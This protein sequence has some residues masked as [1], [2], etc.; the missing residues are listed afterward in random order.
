MLLSRHPFDGDPT[1][2]PFSTEA[3]FD[4]WADKGVLAARINVPGAAATVGVLLTHLQA[5]R[6]QAEV[7]RLQLAD[8]ANVADSLRLSRTHMALIAMG[9]FNVI[10]EDHN[11]LQTDE[12]KYMV[13]LLNLADTW[14][15]QHPNDPG[16]TSAGGVNDLIREFGEDKGERKRLDYILYAPRPSFY[17]HCEPTSCELLKYQSARGIGRDDVRDLSDHYGIVAEYRIDVRP[18]GAITYHID[19][20]PD[21]PDME[22]P[23][24][25]SL[26]AW[27]EDA[28]IGYARA[29]LTE[30]AP[31]IRVSYAD[32]PLGIGRPA[33]ERLGCVFLDPQPLFNCRGD[34][35]S[36]G[37]GYDAQ[38]RRLD[39]AY[40]LQHFTGR[41][42]H[43][44]SPRSDSV[45]QT[46]DEREAAPGSIMTPYQPERQLADAKGES[47]SDH[48]AHLK[49]SDIDY[50]TALY[51]KRTVPLDW[52]DKVRA[53]DNDATI[54][55]ILESGL[56]GTSGSL[57]KEIVRIEKQIAEAQAKI[58][59]DADVYITSLVWCGGITDPGPWQDEEIRFVLT[60][61]DGM[62]C[63]DRYY[64]P[65]KSGQHDIKS[66]EPT[67]IPVAFNPFRIER[68]DLDF[69]LKLEVTE[70][71]SGFFGPNKSHIQYL[72]FADHG[73]KGIFNSIR[74]PGGRPFKSLSRRVVCKG[75][76]DAVVRVEFLA[77][78]RERTLGDLIRSQEIAAYTLKRFDP[79]GAGFG[80]D[81]EAAMDYELSRV[82]GEST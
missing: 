56:T 8:V 11:G 51:G 4:A 45:E 75:K 81:L 15:V 28:A 52:R 34:R 49:R 9:D 47:R 48:H 21:L 17:V 72:R 66:E 39:L 69:E 41:A 26:L 59:I 30:E 31:M 78:G 38:A 1:F 53:L 65:S 62:G 68:I 50:M 36:W 73:L 79:S 20:H 57:G 25:R 43:S 67:H 76:W 24:L 46:L 80:R 58:P 42:L 63:R 29:D 19:A 27:M 32:A 33:A 54:K 71:D 2:H 5:D 82:L 16:A 60:A 10:A 23:A 6:D 40:A 37:L 13:E 61:S 64:Y 44:L 35:W 22:M 74:S 12:Y 14:R 55:D 77:H 18:F 70:L 7:R 3:G